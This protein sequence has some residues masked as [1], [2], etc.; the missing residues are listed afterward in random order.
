MHAF[1]TFGL[2]TS[3]LACL[4]T[5]APAK[6]GHTAKSKSAFPFSQVVAFGDN[7]SDNGNGSA[8]NPLLS[9]SQH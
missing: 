4:S 7:L 3:L 6:K 5:A 2:V 8:V 9:S 1:A